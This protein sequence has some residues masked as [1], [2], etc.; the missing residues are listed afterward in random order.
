MAR[1]I[2]QK[3]TEPKAGD[4]VRTPSEIGWPGE[5]W[6]PKGGRALKMISPSPG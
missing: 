2:G 6:V 4:W 5:D 1:G 3:E